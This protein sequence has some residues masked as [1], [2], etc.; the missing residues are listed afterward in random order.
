M[1]SL[2][3][4]SEGKCVFYA[5]VHQVLFFS[6]FV[7]STVQKLPGVQGCELPPFLPRTCSQCWITAGS[8]TVEGNKPSLECLCIHGNPENLP[9]TRSNFLPPS[10]EQGPVY[11]Q[12]HVSRAP[13]AAYV[14]RTESSWPPTLRRVSTG[15]PLG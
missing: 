14:W 10:R 12:K 15:F 4:L 11:D 5:S 9:P 8:Q 6:L 1:Q 3:S 13:R 7:A 2:K